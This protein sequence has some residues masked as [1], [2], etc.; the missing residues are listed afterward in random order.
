MLFSLFSLFSLTGCVDPPA[1]GADSG[2]LGAD[3]GAS[4]GSVDT[5]TT[6]GTTDTQD[7]EPTDTQD[8]EPT[9]TQDTETEP[10]GPRTFTFGPDDSLLYVQVFKDE[11]TWGS[12]L[13][14][15][16]V[17][18]AS[19]WSGSAVLEAGTCALDFTVQVD[20]LVADEADMRSHVGYG[21]TISSAD[22]SEITDNMLHRD[23]L[24]A[25]SHPTITFASTSCVVDEAALDVVGVMTVR[26]QGKQVSF[27]VPFADDDGALV[28]DL[29]F[30]LRHSDFGFEPYEAYW[31][32]VANS[33]PIVFGLELAGPE[34]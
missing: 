3:T 30:E 33:Q 7:T 10:P 16:H 9:D 6:G 22:R 17:V 12:D 26:G 14:H 28:V 21:D 13:A 24:N 1:T 19:D 23:Q 31:G 34:Q 27:T 11:A 2:S 15:D 5:G 29:G 20:G 32:L 8:T 25:G 18:R 4:T